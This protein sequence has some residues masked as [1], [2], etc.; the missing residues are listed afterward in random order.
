[1]DESDCAWVTEL[2]N[3]RQW[4]QRKARGE[5]DDVIG[6]AIL[7]IFRSVKHRQSAG[8]SMLPQFR[9]IVHNILCDRH[10]RSQSRKKFYQLLREVPGTICDG[11]WCEISDSASTSSPSSRLSEVESK[12]LEGE[13]SMI[14][15]QRLERAM[16]RM[17]PTER[18]FVES[19]DADLSFDEI[20]L[21][22]GVSRGAIVKMANR[23]SQ[24]IE[25]GQL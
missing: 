7:K 22:R 2:L 17:S 1:M 16:R 6:E 10:R 23:I 18:L 12:A 13:R 15:R 8:K 5:T 9:R 3:D 11:R 19:V 20:A 25:S 14:E 4:V 24:K 21:T